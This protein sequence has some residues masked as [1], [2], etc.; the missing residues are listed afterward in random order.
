MPVVYV[1]AV[2]LLNHV[3]HDPPRAAKMKYAF[4]L[5]NHITIQD[6]NQRRGAEMLCFGD[7]VTH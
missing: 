3:L 4:V 5:S 7:S 6:E 2:K 1:I